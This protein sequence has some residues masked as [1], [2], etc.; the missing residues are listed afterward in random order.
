MAGLPIAPKV[1]DVLR[2]CQDDRD[3]CTEYSRMSACGCIN[4][5][6]YIIM[7]HRAFYAGM[8]FQLEQHDDNSPLVSGKG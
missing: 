2:I 6:G 3:F 4:C 5:A 1:T 8:E 7:I